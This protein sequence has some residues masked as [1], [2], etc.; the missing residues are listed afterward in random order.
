M[1]KKEI[2]GCSINTWYFYFTSLTRVDGITVFLILE[3]NPLFT[4]GAELAGFGQEH[5]HEGHR[6]DDQEGKS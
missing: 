5:D 1:V 4:D 2:R 6:A 3:V